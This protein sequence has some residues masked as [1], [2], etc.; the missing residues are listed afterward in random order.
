MKTEK[1]FTDEQLADINKLNY[2]RDPVIPRSPET[3]ALTI[4]QLQSCT[5]GATCG[6][7]GHRCLVCGWLQ[8]FGETRC[9]K[10]ILDELANPVEQGD[11]DES[12]ASTVPG[13]VP[14]MGRDDLVI[15]QEGLVM[16]RT[17]DMVGKVE[18]LI[19]LMEENGM[20]LE[21]WQANA[22]RAVMGVP[23]R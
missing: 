14:F 5:C 1:P 3:P 13:T 20:A 23:T 19:D 15:T 22:F 16:L 12:P 11:S 18:K 7:Y 2:G 9:A 17:D 21:P 6:S 10:T 8:R 4:A